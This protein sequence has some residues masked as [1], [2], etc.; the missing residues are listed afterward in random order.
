M[1]LKDMTITSNKWGL[2]GMNGLS[3]LCDSLVFQCITITF[4]LYSLWYFW[5]VCAKHKT[6]EKG[7]INCVITQ[8]EQSG[9]YCDPNAVIELEGD[10][11][12]V[13]GNNI[14]GYSDWYGLQ[15]Y[16]TSSIIHLLFPLT[17]QSVSTNNHGGG[18]Y[19]GNGEITIVDN[20]GNIIEI[21]NEAH[22][23]DY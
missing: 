23:Y 16:D 14:G 20:D 10:Q 15:T 3:F 18:N 17:K 7:L 13:D 19:G 8:C 9:I 6:L 21:I 5:C 2:F 11:T 4:D 12:K 22:E 1:V